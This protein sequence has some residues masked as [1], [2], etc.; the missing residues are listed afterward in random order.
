MYQQCLDPQYNSL[1]GSAPGTYTG[2]QLAAGNPFC[3]LINR[4][5]IDDGVNIYGAD[6]KFD[7][8]YINQGALYS[9]GYDVQLDWNSDFSDIGLGSIPGN[10]GVNML[11]SKLENYAV[12]PFPGASVVEYTGTTIQFILRLPNAYHLYLQRR[13]ILRWFTLDAFAGAGS[14]AR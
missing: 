6:R 8:A 9:E 4:E 11:Y 3:A 12:A 13:W 10:L 7:A 2:E 1:I 5:Y 14:I